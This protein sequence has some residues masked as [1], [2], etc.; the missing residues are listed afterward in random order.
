M[1]HFTV[2]L[3]SSFVITGCMC[4]D[5]ATIGG[6]S[7]HG[8][9]GLVA[10][11]GDGGV[12]PDGGST[13]TGKVDAGIEVCGNGYDDDNNG[14]ID[15]GCPCVKDQAQTCWTGE[16]VNRRVGACKDGT[17]TCT[18]GGELA[19]WS[20]CANVQ[21]P[22]AEVPG[23]CIDEDC[24]G[25]APGCPVGCG[26]ELSEVC[27]N[28]IDDNCDGKVDCNDP[29]CLSNGACTPC[30]GS[31][32][33]VNELCNDGIDND[34]NGKADCNEPACANMCTMCT[35]TN[36]SEFNC[37]DK[38][39]DDCDGK[40]DC[41][42]P[43]CRFPGQCGC[44]VHE[45]ACH[46]GQDDDCDGA[47]DCADVDCEVCTPGAN[48]YC[49]EPNFCHFGQ[50]TCNSDGTWGKCHEV[51]P[52]SQCKAGG[53]GGIFGTDYDQECCVAAGL[54]CQNYHSGGGSIGMCGT[55]V[56]CKP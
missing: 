10:S 38:V 49:D 5:A 9:G 37:A 53:I 50:Q 1:K 48:R 52:P 25:K 35:V 47:L 20:A 21:L 32:P 40:I 19:D 13:S 15:E 7:V 3:V 23:N 14:F 2:V 56:S 33:E 39:D 54:C 26:G 16:A 42:D 36:P 31:Q 29:T 55:S 6:S 12:R 41:A 11:S 22:T 34:C 24:D 17:Q 43:D 51:T 4:T 28:Q 46:N 44:A 30:V 27:D 18:G 45:T 8:D